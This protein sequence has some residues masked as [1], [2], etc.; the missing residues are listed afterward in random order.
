MRRPRK[1]LPGARRFAQLPWQA[2]TVIGSV[3]YQYGGNLPRATRGSGQ[4]RSPR[5]GRRW[6][7]R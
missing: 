3:A 5:T 4:W 2:R 1:K 6:C 7:G